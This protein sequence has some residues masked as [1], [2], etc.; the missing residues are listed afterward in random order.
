MLNTQNK[1]SS[2]FVGRIPSNVETDVTSHSGAKN[3]YPF[4]LQLSGRLGAVQAHLRAIHGQGHSAPVHGGGHGR[5]GLTEAE[6]SRNDRVS[7][8][9]Q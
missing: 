7:E 4:D 5:M 1:N 8:Y 9:Q 6:S 3:I 2:Y